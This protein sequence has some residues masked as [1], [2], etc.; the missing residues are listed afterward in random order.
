MTSWMK[1]LNLICT[2]LFSSLIS[3]GWEEEWCPFL[4]VFLFLAGGRRYREGRKKDS[5]SLSLYVFLCGGSIKMSAI[6]GRA[7]VGSRIPEI[8][9]DLH[10]DEM[11]CT[12]C[13]LGPLF[14]FTIFPL[15]NAFSK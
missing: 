4:R 7:V 14:Y 8:R 15:T 9:G 6:V 3:S 10:L 13:T 2:V 1:R 5:G 12:G 11:Y